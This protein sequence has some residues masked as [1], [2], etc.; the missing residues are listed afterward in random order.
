[1]TNQVH[2]K[3]ATTYNAASDHF[4]APPL[5][6][7]DRHGKIAVELATL[8]PG[9]RVLDVGCGTG[10]S[11][12]PAAEAVGPDGMVVAMDI[13][14]AMLQ[15]AKDKASA[16]GIRNISFRMA[17]MTDLRESDQSYDVVISVFSL[18][19]TSDMKTQLA[20]LWRL[21]RPGGRLIT[22][23]WGSNAFEP[24]AGA[25]GDALREIRPDI[26]PL[27]RPWERFTEQENIRRLIADSVGVVPRV[28]AAIDRQPLTEPSDW[29]TVALGSGFRWEV[30]QLTPYEQEAVKSRV[31]QV[32]SDQSVCALESSALHAI[33]KKAMRDTLNPTR[34]SQDAGILCG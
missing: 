27:T 31:V 28:I 12:L 13:A 16:R 17:D 2:M 19:F 24:G 34:I 7:W 21:L 10:A 1:M 11:A 3:V 9:E 18:F 29:W 15:R 25:F 8:R 22:T 30:D 6:F 20:K 32:L 26:P 4:D 14:E 33:T 5:G 23:F